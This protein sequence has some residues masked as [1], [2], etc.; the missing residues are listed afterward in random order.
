VVLEFEGADAAEAALLSLLLGQPGV[1]VVELVAQLVEAGVD[2]V[3]DQA[4]LCER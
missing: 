4:A 2:A 1:L 3:V